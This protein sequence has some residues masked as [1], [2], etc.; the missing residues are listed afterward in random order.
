MSKFHCGGESCRKEP[1]STDRCDCICDRCGPHNDA[2]DP[3]NSSAFDFTPIAEIGKIVHFGAYLPAVT[4][5]HGGVLLS[6]GKLTP[7]PAMITC[8]NENG[9]LALIAFA[10]DH[11]RAFDS[12]RY[13]T[14]LK[15]DHWSWPPSVVAELQAKLAR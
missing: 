6:E 5:V 10:I 14:E 4:K 1:Y 15:R 13:S 7:W 12:I 2:R 8:I 9:S 11:I 3:H